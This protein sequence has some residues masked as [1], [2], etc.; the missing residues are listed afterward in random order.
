[1]NIVRLIKICLNETYSKVSIG[2]C[3]S[4]SFPILNGLKQGNDLSPLLFNFALEHSIRK[5]QENQVVNLLGDNMDSINKNKESLIDASMEVGLERNVEKTKYMLLARQQNVGKNHDRNSKQIFELFHI[6]K[7]SV[8]YLNVMIL[9]CI[10]VMRQQTI[11]A[12]R[13]IAK[14]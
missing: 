13:P 12:Y 14:K 11:V 4:D 2:K 9:L 6:F 8:C 3:F 5:V 7:G 1:M 10:L